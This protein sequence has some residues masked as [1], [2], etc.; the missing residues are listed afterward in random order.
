MPIHSAIRR[1]NKY[2]DNLNHLARGLLYVLLNY[3][4]KWR[5]NLGELFYIILF[6]GI[7]LLLQTHLPPGTGMQGCMNEGFLFTARSG[8]ITTARYHC[9]I[10]MTIAN[11][12]FANENP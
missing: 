4:S 8:K 9:C 11:T 2:L 6:L 12:G 1:I 10:P 7:Y 3:F 5:Q